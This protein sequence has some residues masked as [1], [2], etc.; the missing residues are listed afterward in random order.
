[1]SEE[2]I[3]E[4]F[5]ENGIIKTRSRT[6]DGKIQG[7]FETFDEEGNI[8]LKMHYRQGELEGEVE[9]FYKKRITAK[10]SY[11]ENKLNG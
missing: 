2:Q 6:L 8:E 5:F 4:T 1:M 10:R 7:L 11:K 9:T 3:H